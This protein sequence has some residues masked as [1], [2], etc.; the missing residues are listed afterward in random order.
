MTLWEIYGT[1]AAVILGAVSILWVVSLLL[2]D[3]SIIDVFWGAGFVG[4]SWLYFGLTPS[5]LP[6]R[7]WLIG[8]LVTVWGS[9]LSLHL[10][11]RR[12]GKPEDFRYRKWRQE[13]GEKWWWQSFFRVFLLQGFL[14]WLISAPLLAAQIKTSTDRLTALDIAA[15]ALWAIGFF[16]E[17][18][19]DWQLDRFK[20]ELMG[21]T[22]K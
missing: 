9:R 14:V 10:L 18:V 3:S 19:G 5:G 6:V 22:L 20:A 16:F 1:A 13:A 2:K 4:T 17:A 8:A 7:K 21:S 12:W 15:V 11:R